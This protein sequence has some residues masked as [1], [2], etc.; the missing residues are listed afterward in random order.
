MIEPL[1][2]ILPYYVL[3]QNIS[4][5]SYLRSLIDLKIVFIYVANHLINLTIFC[6]CWLIFVNFCFCNTGQFIDWTIGDNLRK[7]HLITL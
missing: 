1:K 4:L 6:S 3:L 5:D 2:L 7:N